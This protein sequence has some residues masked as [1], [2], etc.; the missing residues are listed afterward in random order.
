M[1]K[2][3]LL[4]GSDWPAILQLDASM[5]IEEEIRRSVQIK[6]DVVSLDFKESGFRKVFNLGILCHAWESLMLE[7]GTPIPH[8]MAVIQGLHLA[9]A[10]SQQDELQKELSGNIPIC[11]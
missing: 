3:S 10:L 4:N 8:G 5:D 2:H 7:K 1:I 9:L 6:S 11:K